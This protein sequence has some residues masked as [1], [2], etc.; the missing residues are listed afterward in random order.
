MIAFCIRPASSTMVTRRAV[1]LMTPKA[2]TA[3]GVMH[4]KERR[5]SVVIDAG[6][7]EHAV[8]NCHPLVNTMTTSIARDDLV[9]FLLATGHEPRIEQIGSAAA[10]G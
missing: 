8:I 9:K 10:N 3:F 4:D 6:L 7:M 1:S 2:V 5:V